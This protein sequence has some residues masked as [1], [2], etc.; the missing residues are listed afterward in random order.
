MI[1]SRAFLEYLER[2]KSGS[3]W[4]SWNSSWVVKRQFHQDYL[5]FGI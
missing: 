4:W 2:K 5:F 1:T 3:V